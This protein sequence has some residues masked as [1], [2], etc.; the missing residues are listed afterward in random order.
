MH[1][2]LINGQFQG[3]VIPF[4]LT[5]RQANFTWLMNPSLDGLTWTYCLDYLDDNYIIW[6]I[7][8]DDHL[9]CLHLVFK[10]MRTKV[11]LLLKS[12]KCQFLRERVTFLGHIMSSEGIE[13]DQE[14]R[15]SG[16]EG[17]SREF[18]GIRNSVLSWSD[19]HYRQLI[20]LLQSPCPG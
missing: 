6:S 11:E 20:T 14:D 17:H 7:A 8:F 5:N 1:S 13:T 2:P 16:R 15:S 3:K 9:Y 12:P 10:R 18:K 4:G 19:Q